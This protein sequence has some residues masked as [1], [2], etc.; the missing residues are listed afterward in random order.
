M[1]VTIVAFST[2]FASMFLFACEEDKEAKTVEYYLSHESALDKKLTECKSN[3]ALK[4]TPDCENAGAANYKR[5]A[6]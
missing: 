5:N 1:K 2:L 4:N 3:E 6:L